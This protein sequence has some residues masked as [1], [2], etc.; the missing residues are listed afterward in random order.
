MLRIMPGGS[1]GCRLRLNVGGWEGGE[2]EAAD[3]ECDE[4]EETV[5]SGLSSRLPKNKRPHHRAVCDRSCK[6]QNPRP[7]ARTAP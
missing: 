4:A 1:T 3:G 7:G 6:W 5:Q 2:S